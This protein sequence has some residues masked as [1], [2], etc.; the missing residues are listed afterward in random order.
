MGLKLI[1]ARSIFNF[2]QNQN[3]T[4]CALVEST[5]SA[6]TAMRNDAPIEKK[7]TW[8]WS[9]FVRVPVPGNHDGRNSLN[10]NE[11]TASAEYDTFREE[12]TSTS[13]ALS[14]C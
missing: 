5:I 9:H 1:R 14:V 12:K 8:M 3:A 6:L 4:T 7:Y 10:Q 13:P 11:C 2:R